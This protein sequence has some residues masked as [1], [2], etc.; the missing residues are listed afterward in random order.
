[1][2]LTRG[3]LSITLPAPDRLVLFQILTQTFFMLFIYIVF[4]LLGIIIVLRIIE[5]VRGGSVNNNQ[6]VGSPDVFHANKFAQ[7]MQDKNLRDTQD[8]AK[9]AREAG[10]RATKQAQSV[11]KLNRENLTRATNQAKD[12]FNKLETKARND[13]KQQ[14]MRNNPLGGFGKNK[15]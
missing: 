7:E 3:Q 15:F 9:R 8:A 11:M 12:T 10:E 13:F 14:Q 4:G 2:V 6:N 1:M 5:F